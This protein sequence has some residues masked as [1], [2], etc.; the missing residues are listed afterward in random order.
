MPLST[1]PYGFFLPENPPNSGY[2]I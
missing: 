1:L 2:G